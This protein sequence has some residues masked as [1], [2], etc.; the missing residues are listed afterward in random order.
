M[1][2]EAK[3]IR[4]LSR[5]AGYRAVW[6]ATSK[7]PFTTA[8]LQDPTGRSGRFVGHQIEAEIQYSLVPGNLALQIGHGLC[9]YVGDGHVLSCAEMR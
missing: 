8:R 2:I 9:L 6:L 1:R 7:D 4:H 3:P 5:F